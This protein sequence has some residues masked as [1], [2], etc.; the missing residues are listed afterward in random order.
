MLVTQPAFAFGEE[1]ETAAESPTPTPDPHTEAYY[2]AP[3]SNSIPGW[4]QGPQVEAR[5]AVMMDVYT[6]AILY[7]KNP[8]EKMY[9]ASITKILTALLGCEN[10]SV[11]NKLVMSETA[12]HGISPAIPVFTQILTRSLLSIRH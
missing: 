1:G 3:E 6:G 8:D 11:Q 5:S 9:P 12:A 10:L 7:S 2:A 4:P